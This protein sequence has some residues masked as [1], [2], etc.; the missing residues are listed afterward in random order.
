MDALVRSRVCPNHLLGR[1]RPSYPAISSCS[2]TSPHSEPTEEVSLLAC[3]VD[4]SP[5]P[6][7]TRIWQVRADRPERQTAELTAQFCNVE[8]T[9]CL[10]I[11]SGKLSDELIQFSKFCR[12]RIRLSCPS[13]H[14]PDFRQLEQDI[15][16]TLIGRCGRFKDRHSG[17]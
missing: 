17:L 9:E 1:G 14:P 10:L 13:G 4:Q 8:I 12:L 2:T 15:K 6:P 5:K 11:Q 7:E 16:V 3:V